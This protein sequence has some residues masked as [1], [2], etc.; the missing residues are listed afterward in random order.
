M[1]RENWGKQTFSVRNEMV[2]I[3][4]IIIFIW[5]PIEYKK[6][7]NYLAETL[8]LDKTLLSALPI[9]FILNM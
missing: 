8:T 4:N 6:T 5:F 7:L 9:F 3:K 1:E 2:Y